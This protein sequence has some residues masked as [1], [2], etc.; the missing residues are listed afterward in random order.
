M[1]GL[2]HCSRAWFESWGYFPLFH[3]P[4]LTKAYHRDWMLVPIEIGPD[5]SAPVGAARLAGET[6]LNVGEPQ[7][8]GQPSPLIAMERYFN[9]VDL[10][11]RSLPCFSN[12]ALGF[13]LS[14]NLF[15]NISG[16][17]GGRTRART[18]DPLIKSPEHC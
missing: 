3:S 17:L 10:L 2:T 8:V 11:P 14:W 1:L 7:L 15:C 5:I 12:S 6:R 4:E 9:G 18:W 16:L 13:E